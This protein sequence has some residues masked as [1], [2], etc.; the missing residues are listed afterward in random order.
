MQATAELKQEISTIGE[1]KLA[2]HKTSDSRITKTHSRPFRLLCSIKK[3][4]RGSQLYLPAKQQILLNQPS[5][6]VCRGL[7]LGKQ[8]NRNFYMAAFPSSSSDN[9]PSHS[10]LS[11]Q[12]IHRAQCRALFHNH[13]ASDRWVGWPCCC[14]LAE[15][16]CRTS[17]RC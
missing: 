14:Q 1:S 4:A 16:H 13:R 2:R 8:G 3:L 17:L 5:R 10:S 7:A 9:T 11:S 15:I 12:W 6:T